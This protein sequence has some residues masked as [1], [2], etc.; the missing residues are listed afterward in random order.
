VGIKSLCCMKGQF[1]LAQIWC[2]LF[3]FRDEKNCTYN[4]KL[5]LHTIE[6][7]VKSGNRGEN[8]QFWHSRASNP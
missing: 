3:C 2:E 6:L 1:L 7:S 8:G 4:A 5:L